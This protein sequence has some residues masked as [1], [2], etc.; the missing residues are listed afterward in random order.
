MILKI[1]DICLYTGLT[2]DGA[3]CAEALKWMREKLG[4]D[5]FNHLHYG[6]PDV[7]ED[8]FAAL[9][10]WW[11]EDPNA[12]FTK[13]PIVIYDEIDSDFNFKRRYIKG[14]SDIKDSNLEQL[15]KL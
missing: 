1:K 14:L 12:V 15:A 8:N 9:N 11:P 13:F 5:G 2:A 7:H 4:R 10:T 3:E 6:D